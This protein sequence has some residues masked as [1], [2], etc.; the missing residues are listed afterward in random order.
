MKTKYES[1][2]DQYSKEWERKGIAGKDLG[3]EWGDDSLTRNIHEKFLAPRVKSDATLLEI[4]PGGGKYSAGV[5]PLCKKLICADVSSEMLKRTSKRLGQGANLETVKLNGIDF[6]G[7]ADQ[8]IDFAF[9]IDVFVHLDLEDIYVYLR[10]FQR[11]LKPGGPLVLHFASLMTFPGFDLFFREADIN[12]AQFKQIGRINFITPEL[13]RRLFECVGFVVDEIDEEISP[14]DFVIAAH[15]AEAPKNED[16]DAAAR[17]KRVVDRAGGG[18]IA[19]DLLGEL[20]HAVRVAP[21]ERYICK[22]PIEINGDERQCI[23]AHPP[24][25]V[26][27]ALTIPEKAELVTAA[28]MNPEIWERCYP[29]GILFRIAIREGTNE[30]ELFSRTI[31]PRE[32]HEDRKWHEIRVDLKKFGGRVVFLIFE[33]RVGPGTNDFNWCAFAEPVLLAR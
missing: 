8:S 13:A 20:G 24:S 22:T 12:R 25:Q 31:H 10:E 18:T 7:V 17:T 32:R 6:T 26:G 9:S 15:K 1:S 30:T 29:D 28:G 4:G 11:V 33:T 16:E 3:V 2:W 5:S 19:R 14:R 27:Y 23:F 21:D